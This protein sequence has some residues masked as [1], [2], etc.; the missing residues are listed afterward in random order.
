MVVVGTNFSNSYLATISVFNLVLAGIGMYVLTKKWYCF[1][2]AVPLVLFPPLANLLVLLIVIGSFAVAS[3]ALSLKS[4]KFFLTALI[5]MDVFLVSSGLLTQIFPFSLGDSSYLVL[6][7]FHF[8]FGVQVGGGDLFGLMLLANL[9]IAEKGRRL[10]VG[11]VYVVGIVVAMSL[12][13]SGT[14]SIFPATIP[15][16]PALIVHLRTRKRQTQTLNV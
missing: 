3:N 14:F 5:I 10:L 7:S 15:L 1:P 2:L 16:G 8:P 13:L 11:C 6:N 9:V 12:V 4:T